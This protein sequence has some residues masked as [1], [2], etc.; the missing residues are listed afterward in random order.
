MKYLYLDYCEKISSDIFINKPEN[1][2]IS[3]YGCWQTQ[4]PDTVKTPEN[5]VEIQMWC[6]QSIHDGGYNKILEFVA[7]YYQYAFLNSLKREEV[8]SIINSSSFSILNTS[9]FFDV[10]VV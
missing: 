4:H 3:I 6:F 9:H 10:A 1:I 5:I 2:Q 7:E 8:E